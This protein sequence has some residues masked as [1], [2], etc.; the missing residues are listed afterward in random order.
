MKTSE[1][2]ARPEFIKVLSDRQVVAA[3]PD[4]L[5]AA[6]EAEADVRK[7]AYKAL[8]R[9]AGPEELPRI[10]ESLVENYSQTVQT[11][12]ERSII[13]V[14]K[15]IPDERTRADS[16]LDAFKREERTTVR[17]SLLRI[18]G[19]IANQKA[20]FALKSTLASTDSEQQDTA[21]RELAAWP[22]VDALPFLETVLENPSNETHRILAFRGYVRLLGQSPPLPQAETL[23]MYRKAFAYAATAQQTKLVLAGLGNLSSFAALDL[24]ISQLDN[25]PVTE[26]AASAAIKIAEKLLTGPHKGQIRTAM[27]KI[28]AVSK[29]PDIR[30]GAN[31]ILRFAK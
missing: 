13:A 12:A 24:A 5:E 15:K 17:C 14:S 31:Q 1:S 22:N 26:E 20:L 28:L 27:K 30:E 16:V 8:G 25:K 9:L 29:N 7:A 6:C 3:V 2:A 23:K 18:L 21:L 11:D 19:G 10:I 4:L